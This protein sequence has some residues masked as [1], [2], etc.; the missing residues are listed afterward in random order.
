VKQG[1]RYLTR[2]LASVA[3]IVAAFAGVASAEV[4]QLGNLRVDIGGS[5]KPKQ[6]P[7]DKLA[8]I[9]LRVDGRISTLDGSVPP[10]LE[11]M[12]ID[13]DRNGTVYTKGLATCSVNE[14]E[15]TL[16]EDALRRCRD[17]LVGRGS[18]KAI[19]DFPDQDPFDAPAPVLAFNGEKQGGKPVVIFHA[20]AHVPTPTTFVVPSVISN[21]P[22]RAFG[23]RVTVNVPPIAGGNG[24]LVEFHIKV[25]RTWKHKGQRRS[26]LI[27]KCASG[28]FIARGDLRFSDGSM[29]EGSV[30]RECR[31]GG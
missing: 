24:H 22:G 15:N 12:V 21:A 1:R 31:A 11:T 6:L 17:A 13:F 28:H 4:I 5:F 30:V 8:P 29:L 2:V 27:A 26:Y 23:K 25:E 10:G 14:L 9:S 16:T 19:V 18:A 3:A 7:R 20:F